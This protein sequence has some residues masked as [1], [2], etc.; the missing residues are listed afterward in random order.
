[1][2]KHLRIDNR[3]LHGQVA[4]IW[5]DYIDADEIL[6]VNDETASDPLQKKVLQLSA[7]G[8]AVIVEG[9]QQAI[10]LVRA[11]PDRSYFVIARYPADALALIESGLEIAEVNVGNASPGSNQKYVTVSQGIAVSES[12][13]EIYRKIASIRGGLYCQLTVDGEKKD[14]IDLLNKA[15]L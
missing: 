3:L 15:G 8:T 6:I 13:A 12:D 7:K 5:K 11:N 9:I 10:E 1:M 14:F 4:V 2:I